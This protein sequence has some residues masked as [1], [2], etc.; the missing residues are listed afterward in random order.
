MNN[1]LNVWGSGYPGEGKPTYTKI[2]IAN[3][4]FT[5]TNTSRS[6]GLAG[7]YLCYT[8]Q[9]IASALLPVRLLT[10]GIQIS[11]WTDLQRADHRVRHRRD[12]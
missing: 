3:S 10:W 8:D 12:V 5:Q 1:G 4:I 6:R 2:N 11:C 7:A 9:M